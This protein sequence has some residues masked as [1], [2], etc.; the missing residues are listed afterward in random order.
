MNPASLHL[1]V[2]HVPIVLSVIGAVMILLAIVLRR[3]GL[4]RF[5]MGCVAIAGL[6]A[7]AAF[8]TGRMGAGTMLNSWYVQ[9]GDVVAHA[10][11]GQLAFWVTLAAALV[12]AYA[13]RRSAGRPAP[14]ASSFPALLRV[15]TVL[16]ALAAAGTSIYA[17]QLGN[18][19]VHGAPALVRPPAGAGS[20]AAQPNG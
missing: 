14:G 3:D 18:R 13:I 17:G 9:R 20:S 5:G 7:I 11:A 8:V 6:G 2:D 4:W 10:A 15:L 16:G 1:L 19:I 12:C